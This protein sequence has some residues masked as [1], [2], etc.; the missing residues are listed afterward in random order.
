MT[1]VF[2]EQPLALYGCANYI[3]L[4]KMVKCCN[5]RKFGALRTLCERRCFTG[6][7]PASM[8]EA[9]PLCPA[10]PCRSKK[11][12][13]TLWEALI[14]CVRPCISVRS[15]ASLWEALSFCQKQPFCKCVSLWETQPLCKRHTERPDILVI[16]LIYMKEAWPLIEMQ[17]ISARVNNPKQLSTYMF[18]LHNKYLLFFCRDNIILRK[19]GGIWWEEEKAFRGPLTC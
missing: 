16:G 6:T 13:A 5:L 11:C 4:S 12:P 19:R 2:V 8:A 15:Y 18:F 14:L 7:H 10:L 9:L 17:I 3:L 1:E